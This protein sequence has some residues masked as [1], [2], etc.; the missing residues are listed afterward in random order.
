MV[1]SAIAGGLAFLMLVVYLAIIR[2]Q[3]DGPELRVILIASCIAAAGS[4]A[5]AAAWP[6]SP[7]RRLVLMTAAAGG[8]ISLG[9]IGM[10]SI[11]LPLFVGGVL[12]TIGSIRLAHSIGRN[13][14]S[15]LPALAAGIAGFLLPV[16]VLFTPR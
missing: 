12:A 9:I 14:P 15:R 6:A 2:S 1:L 4:C 16:A 7:H 8:L 13:G 3:G 10:W 5:V 11:G